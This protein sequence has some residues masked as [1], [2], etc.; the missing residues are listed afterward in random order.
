MLFLYGRCQL[1]LSAPNP[2]PKDFSRKVL[3]NLKSFRQS[4]VVRSEGSSLA[5]LSFKKGK[6]GFFR[7]FSFITGLSSYEFI[8]LIEKRNIEML[9]VYKEI[10]IIKSIIRDDR[11]EQNYKKNICR[12]FIYPFY[13]IK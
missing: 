4:E 9:A 5:Y 13:G 8:Q 1:G 7:A 12:F 10:N 2:E 6:C 3:W 11:D